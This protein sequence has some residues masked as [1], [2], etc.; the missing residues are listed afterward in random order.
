VQATRGKNVCEYDSQ[1]PLRIT[2]TD[3][4]PLP[5]GLE[6]CPLACGFS[7]DRE[8]LKVTEDGRPPLNIRLKSASHPAGITARTAYTAATLPHGFQ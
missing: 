1:N 5:M 4:R 6:G 2:S 7:I 3:L 8:I